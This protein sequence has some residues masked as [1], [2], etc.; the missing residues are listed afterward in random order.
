MKEKNAE[1]SARIDEIICILHT[2]PN[3]FANALG[4]SRAQTIYDILEGKSAPSYDFFKRFTMSGYSVF[5][6]L[7]WLLSGEGNPIVEERYLESDLP[8][9]KGEMTPEEAA[10]KLKEIKAKKPYNADQYN[11]KIKPLTYE[12][13]I[14]QS[15]SRHTRN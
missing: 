2:N 10:Q 4:Y 6:N 12:T 13:R 7:R 1:I 15:G 14:C 3:K 5:I 9:I 11:H 8:I